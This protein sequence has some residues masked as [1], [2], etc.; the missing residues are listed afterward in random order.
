MS[1]VWD[2]MVKLLAD[3]PDKFKEDAAQRLL[4][5]LDDYESWMAEGRPPLEKWAFVRI[6]KDP[7][8][9]RYKGARKMARYFLQE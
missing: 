9:A 6:L 3:A 8:F 5:V 2:E 7:A 1:S 4:P